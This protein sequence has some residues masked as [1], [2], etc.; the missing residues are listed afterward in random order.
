MMSPAAG[1]T[2]RAGMVLVFGENENSKAVTSTVVVHTKAFDGAERIR[3]VGPVAFE[4]QT[5]IHVEQV[6]IPIVDHITDSLGVTKKSFDISIVNP[7]A[8]SAYDLGVEISG[9][10]SDVP[11]LLA[12]LSAVLN[13][14]VSDD[15]VM[16]GHIASCDGDIG[17]VKALPAKIAAAIEDITIRHLIYPNLDADSSLAVLSPLGTS[18]AK[19]AV[20]NARGRLKLTAVSNIS[21]LVKAVF[22]DEATVMASLSEHFFVVDSSKIG[23]ADPVS[24]AVRFL[25]EN[26]DTRFWN[27]L[28]RYLHAGESEKA[29]ALLLAHTHFHIESQTYPKEFGRKLIQLLRS[30]PPAVRKLKISLPLLP[31]RACVKLSQFAAESDADDIRLLY[32]AA[33]GKVIWT[34]PTAIKVIQTCDKTTDKEDQ[35]VVD[36]IISEID[37]SALASA[38]DMPIDT[39]RATYMID[40]LSVE[41]SEQFYDC[42]SAFYLHLQRHINSPSESLDRNTVRADAIALIDRI[43]FN[44]G[45]LRAAMHEAS[46]PV[47]G[48]MKF[49]LDCMT[50]QFKIDA[51]NKHVNRVIKEA[52]SPMEP[53]A[54]IAFVRTL[55]DR[56]SSHLPERI[57][58]A[59]PE[60]F[61][62]EEESLKLIVTTYVKSLDRI[63]EV[64]RR[65]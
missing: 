61:L 64:F 6:L 46:E 38:V 56:L 45:G 59:P 40:S 51:R 35:A 20:I 41:S 36:A 30:L 29:K 1:S 50:E 49:I 5:A 7:G 65:F 63:S 48:G 33:S 9:F 23:Q 27:V 53:D 10:S 19:V 54:Q 60:S 58:S 12:M 8:A 4:K 26:N 24:L 55:L 39:A 57:A 42:I 3:F 2:G 11:I 37:C 13:I 28:E 17:A 32:N 16:T 31:P 22:T 52:L 44:K 14:S 21:D 25:A 43:F 34:E 15:T 62:K 47:H 18:K